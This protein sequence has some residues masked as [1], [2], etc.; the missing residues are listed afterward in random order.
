MQEVESH[1]DEGVQGNEGYVHCKQ[2]EVLLVVLADTVID[3]ETMVVHLVNAL[4]T[5]TAVVGSVRLDVAAFGTLVHHL[6]RLQLQT[7][8]ELFSG[9]SFG[10]CPGVRQHGPAVGSQGQEGQQVEHSSVDDAVHVVSRWNQHDKEDHKLR[11]EDQKPVHNGTGDAI[12]VT[13]KPHG[14]RRTRVGR[15]DKLFWLKVFWFPLNVSEVVGGDKLH[16]LFC[17][18]WHHKA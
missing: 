2:D 12:A 9:I 6:P 3:P 16:K 13:D 11:I 4:L 8:D 17:P 10:Y 5:N 14:S 1:H 7:L 18:Y 15:W